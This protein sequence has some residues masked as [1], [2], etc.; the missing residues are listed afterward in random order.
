MTAGERITAEVTSWPGV[1]AGTGRRGEFAFTVGRRQLGH[2]H[3]DHAAHFSFPK[4]IWAELFEQG[5]IVHH[6]V[7]PGKQ[8]PAARRIESD[9]DVADVIA[10][11]RLNYERAVA[12]GSRLRG[13]H[14]SDPAPLPF[15]PGLHI[16]SFLLERPRGNVLI[17]GAPGVEAA[18]F[19]DAGGIG[20][21]YLGHGHEAAFASEL[22]D[23][24]LFVHEADRAAVDPVRHVR[25][26]FS[27]RHAL[28]EDLEVIPIPGHTPGA[29]AYLWDSGEHRMLFTGDT[30]HLR[31]G[32][33]VPAVLESSD[34]EAYVASLELIRELDFDVLVPWAASA[35]GPW[36]S[37]TDRADAR[38]RVDAII[39]RVRG[40]EDRQR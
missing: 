37:L 3:G 22:P 10:L 9:A 19:A 33:W 11:L 26:T 34:R 29:T 12:K 24:P 23:V 25:G 5:R 18:T 15:A 16:R 38:R 6:P 35:G 31:G 17:Y 28:D 27:R 4:D 36:H 20:R 30:I 8:G 40:G 39:D 13:L 7:F 14:P 1:E 32:E 2:L 21:A